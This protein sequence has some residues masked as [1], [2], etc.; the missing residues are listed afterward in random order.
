MID[1][2][3]RKPV[4]FRRLRKKCSMKSRFFT[5]ITISAFPAT[6]FPKA[7]NAPKTKKATQFPKKKYF[8]DLKKIPIIYD[9]SYNYSNFTN[10]WKLISYLEALS[11]LFSKLMSY[12]QTPSLVGFTIGLI[13]VHTITHLSKTGLIIAEPPRSSYQRWSH[14][15]KHSRTSFQTWSHI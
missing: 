8:S 3:F 7:D 14:I 2:F 13:F 1:Q 15:C 10:N 4:T 12:L 11:P 5:L 9:Y 6:T